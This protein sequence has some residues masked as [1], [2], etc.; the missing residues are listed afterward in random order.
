M[1]RFATLAPNR[2]SKEI[3][4]GTRFSPEALGLDPDKSIGFVEDI[5]PPVD[6][7][8]IADPRDVTITPVE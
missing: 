1:G 7:P 5:I 6:I 2:F 3:L 4:E 8:G